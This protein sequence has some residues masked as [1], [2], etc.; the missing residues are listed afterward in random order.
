[1]AKHVLSLE[2]PDTM[3]KCIFRVVDTSVYATTIPV[4]CPLLQITPPGYIHPVNFT[5]PQILP[6]FNLN[7]TACD[8]ELQVSDCGTTFYDVPDGIYIVKYSVEPKDLVYVEYN[9]LRTTCADNRIKEIYCSLSLGACDP[10]AAI[11]DKLNQV[12][13]IQ[14]YLKAAKAYVEDCHE[15]TKGM[16]LYRYAVKLIDKL[17]CSSSCKT[18]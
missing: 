14:Q 9:H 12:R 7:L 8:L 15:P 2:I 13:L 6:G 11:K 17:S 1:M 10:P 4:T 5:N 18:C 16:E 3:N